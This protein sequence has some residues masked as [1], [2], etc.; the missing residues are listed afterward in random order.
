MDGRT[1]LKGG[2]ST[3]AMGIT[4]HEDV[5]EA[6]RLAFTMDIPFWPQLPKLSYYEDMYVQAMEHFPGVVIEV[7]WKILLRFSGGISPLESLGPGNDVRLHVQLDVHR[8]PH[9]PLTLGWELQVFVPRI[10]SLHESGDCRSRLSL[11]IDS[12]T[13]R[14][15]DKR[16]DRNH[17]TENEAVLQQ[18]DEELF[19]RSPLKKVNSE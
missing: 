16:H 14:K 15:A 19:H 6:L 7:E 3:T 17:G 1:G 11:Q 4:P 18:H 5:D 9:N 8:V 10:R 2:L 12:V 13:G